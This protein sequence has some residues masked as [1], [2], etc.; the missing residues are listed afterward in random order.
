MHV[1]EIGL[2]RPEAI[3]S[4]R[5]ADTA[6]VA[7]EQTDF[8]AAAHGLRGVA[9]MM[10]FFAHLLG[11]TAEHI[12]FAD[13]NYVALIQAPW[14]FGRWGV[15][16][17]FAISGFVILP[18]VLR[19]APREFALRRA[20]RLY[21][22]F[23]AF[24]LLF[25]GLNALTNAYPSTNNLLAIFGGLTF[26]NLLTGTEQLTPNAWSLTFEVIFYVFACLIAHFWIRRDNKAVS[27]VLA[28]L[29]FAFL[30]RFP[31]AVYFLFGI[32][33]RIL[34]V[35]GIR[36][37]LQ[38]ARPLE[39]AAFLACAAIT[40]IMHFGYEPEDL[41]NPLVYETMVATLAYFYLAVQPGSLTGKLLDNKPVFYLGAVSYSLYLVH[42]YVYFACRDM[43]V[44]FG[45]FS[46]DWLASMTLFFL[47]ST[48]AA[49]I[50]THAVHHLLERWPYRWFFHQRIYRAPASSD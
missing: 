1:S 33:V 7:A 49:L 43:F 18:S 41:A 48:P 47:V 50:V 40:S 14:N 35:R 17:F 25:I 20:L 27:I 8:N 39:A 15:E 19:Y 12:Y 28:I 36:P 6:A 34:Y 5:P 42:P 37:S 32:L 22:L 38:W 29:A 16:L 3:L 30:C 44:R 46:D 31:I 10:V 26:L 21:P 24:S 45:L 13:A 23:L 9:S 2:N 11:G 4:P